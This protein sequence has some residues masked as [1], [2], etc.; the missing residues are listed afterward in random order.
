MKFQKNIKFLRRKILKTLKYEIHA[1]CFV[2][3]KYRT[4]G[5]KKCPNLIRTSPKPLIAHISVQ[6]RMPPTLTAIEQFMPHILVIDIY[7]ICYQF[8]GVY[9]SIWPS[10]YQPYKL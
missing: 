3:L 7:S 5:I 9:T 4:L 2:M 8:P 6:S 1:N 10:S